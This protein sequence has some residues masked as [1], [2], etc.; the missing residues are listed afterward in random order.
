MKDTVRFAMLTEK[1]RTVIALWLCGQTAKQSAPY[2]KI[3]D[4]TVEYHRERVKCKLGIYCASE[5]HRAIFKSGNF[6]E[7]LKHGVKLIYGDDDKK[8]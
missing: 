5:L 8:E 6:F 1:E 4:R 7:I 2:L 3:S